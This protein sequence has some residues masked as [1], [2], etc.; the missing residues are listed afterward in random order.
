MTPKK[1]AAVVLG[2]AAAG[3]SLYFS[4]GYF[5]NAHSDP[6]KAYGTVDT[7]YVS[8]AFE[9]QGRIQEI[10]VEEG[11]FVKKGDVL[12]RLDV[13]ALEIQKEALASELKAAQARLALALEG[14][15]SEDVDRARKEAAARAAQVDLAEKTFS[16][17]EGLARE[18][19]ASKA[20]LDEARAA[21]DTSR[22]SWEASLAALSALEAGSRPQEIDL[23]AAQVDAAESALELAV[24]QIEVASVLR[25]PGALL[26]RSRLAEVGDMAYPQR[27]VMQLALASP[28][29]VKAYVGPKVLSK[30]KTGGEA[31]VSTDFSGRIPGRITYISNTAEFTPKTVQTEDLRSALVYE[32]R[33]EV[34][35][36][37]MKL[38][39]GQ[40]VGVEFNADD[41]L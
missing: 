8:L 3:T 6:M 37:E 35:D 11:D 24:H 10:L 28:K 21:L 34:E 31:V 2:L 25:A 1:L 12:A 16:R 41:S 17:T 33:I 27:V 4:T 32:V 26:V 29:F 15:R 18:N 5:F 14:P 9:G 39:L 7:R 38:F 30:I 40:P 19:A 22:R 13:R 23:A 36:P 20:A